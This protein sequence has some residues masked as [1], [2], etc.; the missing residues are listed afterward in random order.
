[1]KKFAAFALAITAATAAIAA[2]VESTDPA[3]VPSGTYELDPSHVGVAAT[4]S[5]L[6]FSNAVV[7]FED[8]SGS[9]S[10]DPANPEASSADIT[11]GAASLNSGWAARDGHLRSPEFFNV[12][13]HPTI[14]FKSASLK[15]TGASTAALSGDLTLLGVTRPVTLDVTFKGLG[16]AFD[17]AT[18]IGFAASGK[19]KR[20]D[21]GMM[22]F[23]P[24]VGDEA[25]ITIDAEF[26]KKP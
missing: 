6:G 25:A 24:L 9:V 12:A 14:T 11:I 21:F 26:T 1:M 17:P 3:A 20:S 10:Y 5:H 19:I 22:T 7:R 15:P 4:V 8:V 2:G 18:R 16:K 23:L 13:A